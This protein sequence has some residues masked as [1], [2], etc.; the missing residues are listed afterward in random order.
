MRVEQPSPRSGGEWHRDLDADVRGRDQPRVL[1]IPVPAVRQMAGDCKGQHPPARLVE[2]A[3]VGQ[4]EQLVEI[5][6]GPV[7]VD[8]RLERLLPAEVRGRPGRLLGLELAL[9]FERGGQSFGELEPV[10]HAG[11]QA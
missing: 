9:A 6:A 8:R 2:P 3:Q 1:G 7:G 5:D 11:R 4:A 10:E